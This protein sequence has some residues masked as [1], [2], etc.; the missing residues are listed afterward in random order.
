M[1]RSIESKRRIIR[2]LFVVE[3]AQVYSM[4]ID[5]SHGIGWQL[6]ILLEVPRHGASTCSGIDCLSN[7]H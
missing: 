3:L 6:M 5:V 2:M 1:A 4:A 7:A